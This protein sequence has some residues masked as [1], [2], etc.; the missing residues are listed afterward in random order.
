M[1]A[2]TSTILAAGL[3]G[4]MLFNSLRNKTP[5]GPAAPTIPELPELERPDSFASTQRR[6]RAK[7]QITGASGRKS[8]LLT[9]PSGLDLA[10]TQKKTLL[11]S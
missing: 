10:P 3:V 8:T 7:A 5:Q 1:A 11:G 2:A 6:K 4:G 9:G